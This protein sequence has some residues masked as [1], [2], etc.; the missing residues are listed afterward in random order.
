MRG[1][2]SRKGWLGLML[3]RAG[4]VQALEKGAGS[5]LSVGLRATQS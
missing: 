2:G 3:E 1:R 4:I 5:A